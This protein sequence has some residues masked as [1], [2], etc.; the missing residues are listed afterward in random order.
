MSPR[1]QEKVL[2]S[3]KKIICNNVTF[4]YAFKV[5]NNKKKKVLNNKK[6]KINLL[7]QH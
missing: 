2:L 3:Y 4:S 7:Q 1:L 6:G 5:F